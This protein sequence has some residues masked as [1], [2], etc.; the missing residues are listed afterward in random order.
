[1]LCI[2]GLMCNQMK[3]I[4][5][6]ILIFVLSTNISHSQNKFEFGLSVGSNYVTYHGFRND[7]EFNSKISFLAGL[8]SEY[9]INTNLRIC[10]DLFFERKNTESNVLGQVINP[11]DNP[12]NPTGN[13][14]YYVFQ[15]DYLV[16]PVQIKY[17]FKKIDSF[18]FTTGIFG[19]YL[20]NSYYF[21]GFERENNSNRFKKTDFGLTLGIGRT[22]D[23]NNTSKFKVEL[24]NNFG[25]SDIN[26]DEYF[27]SGKIKT[28]SLNLICNYSFN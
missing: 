14:I 7:N 15:N 23:I 8:T 12:L 10:F 11:G 4:I 22:F 27:F 2:L 3:K 16:L 26:N 17:Q 6:V 24:R 20:L 18:Y 5:F 25:V 13:K 19:G 1:M 9:K 28:N 21:D